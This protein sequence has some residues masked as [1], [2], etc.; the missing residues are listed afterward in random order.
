MEK[1]LFSILS[2]EFCEEQAFPHVSE[3]KLGY[4]AP[5][6]IPVSTAQYFNQS[7]VNVSQDFASDVYQ[8][9]ISVYQQYH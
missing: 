8:Q 4:K 9:Y 3:G 2:D 1:N 6:D 7:L 5:R